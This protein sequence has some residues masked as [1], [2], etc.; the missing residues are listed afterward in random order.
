MLYPKIWSTF[1]IHCVDCSPTRSKPSCLV[2]RTLQALVLLPLKYDVP[3][4]VMKHR[5]KINTLQPTPKSWCYWKQIIINGGNSEDGSKKFIVLL[6]SKC[7]MHALVRD[8]F[9]T[10]RS[11]FSNPISLQFNLLVTWNYFINCH[12]AAS[13]PSCGMWDLSPQYPGPSPD[14]V[15]NLSICGRCGP[16]CSM[17]C[18][19]YSPQPG[20]KP[21]SWVGRWI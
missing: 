19:T 16:G 17:S 8:L 14:A 12:L 9:L 2:M 5:S 6:H 13:G 18:G 11:Y 1:C 4:L 21:A 20:I 15:C 3:V 10:Y 7:D